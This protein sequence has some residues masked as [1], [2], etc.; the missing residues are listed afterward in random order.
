MLTNFVLLVPMNFSKAA[1]P[2]N[3]KCPVSCFQLKIA[4]KLYN[5]VNLWY[6]K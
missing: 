2:Y 6:D 1:E 5:I 3:D 4:I